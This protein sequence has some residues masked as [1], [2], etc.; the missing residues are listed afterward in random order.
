[1]TNY[2]KIK[3]MTTTELAKF[4]EAVMD[5]KVEIWHGFCEVCSGRLENACW[6]CTK[7]WL[8]SEAAK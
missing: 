5:G 7:Q 8:E 3:A 2:E 4:I 6:T 1:M